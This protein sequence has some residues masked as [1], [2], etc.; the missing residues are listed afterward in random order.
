VSDKTMKLRSALST[1]AFSALLFGCGGGGGGGMPQV[2]P[3]TPLPPSPPPP[4]PAPNADSFRTQ[5]YKA[6]SSL[7]QVH[8][9]DAY[10]LG[11]TGS[12]VIVGVV[13]FNFNLGS[14]EV[15]YHPASVG[16]NAQA[17][18]LY[19]AQLGQTS[20]TSPHGHAVAGLI[21]AKKDDTFVHGI[22]FNAQVLAVD[23]FSDVNE[24]QISQ[25]GM[26]YHISDPWGYI[27]S[28]GAK[29][30]S[31]SFGYDASDIVS[32]PPKV[33]EGYVITSPSQAV[34]NGALLVASA[35]N[36]GGANPSLSNQDIIDELSAMNK[37]NNGPG[38]FIIA[39]SVNGNNQISS[40]SN[41]A[42]NAK[43]HY[44]VAPGED[45]TVLWMGGL[46][47]GKGTSFATPLIS[48]AAALILDRWPNLT[49]R[50]IADILF[51]SATDLGASGVDATY[52]HGLL[53]VEAALHPMGASTLA[54]A[55]GAAPSLSATG[56]VLSSAFG[57][58]PAFRAALSQVT[59]LDGFGRDFT[60]DASRAV[61]SRPNMPDL[62][63]M[64]EQ[65]FRWR[66]ASYDVGR[67]TQ[68]SYMLRE[69]RT[70]PI[71]AFRS[72]NGAED[73]Q[74]HET[75]FQF[76]GTTDGTNWSAGSGLS[77]REALS[78]READDPFATASLTGAFFPAIGSGRGAF[79]TA[80]FALSDDTG[81]TLGIAEDQ[82]RK[83]YDGAGFAPDN[84]THS[85]AL[86]LDHDTARTT[87][88]FELGAL[89]EDGGVFG[90]LAAGGL[91][92]SERGTTLWTTA[93]S[94]TALDA[95]WSVKTSLT[96]AASGVQHP[97]SSL[98][99]SI[100]PAYATSFSFGLGG[101]SLFARGDALA[102]TVGQ[103]LRAE[104]A[105][106]SLLTGGAVDRSTGA[107]IMTAA[108]SSLTPSGREFD[109]ETAYRFALADWDLTTSVAYAV[110]A[111]HVRGQNAVTGVLWLSRR[112]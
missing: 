104:Q 82:L 67:G 91:R 92:L 84:W 107:V 79:A 81:L 78:P 39:G 34:A 53:N 66:S 58:A 69:D 100:G 20:D 4:P 68:F 61:Y 95:R 12:G 94:E 26:T 72:L 55:N 90:T 16:P 23:Y 1:V 59:I 52:G 18:A 88:G 6:Q 75:V 2:Q 19:E 112:F 48:G 98:V 24:T 89:V 31:V 57:D 56:L 65:R 22:A 8:A 49:G 37:L 21:A 9:A 71:N 44:M 70:D 17:I 77:L 96:V 45:I 27:T 13:D 5:E 41:R 25:G 76:S 73:I 87:F 10:A 42:G 109:L 108:Q 50:E 106:V 29:I 64:M 33:T 102:I 7:D 101:K 62:F 32:N 110:D 105:P 30:L 80:R 38:A 86:K 11:Y 74:S 46:A 97:G 40:F 111:N 51:Q 54:V 15:N 103:P 93:T 14:T 43:D 47:L 60:A 35:G 36:S 99:S 83:T 85:V 3:Q 28:H 63:G